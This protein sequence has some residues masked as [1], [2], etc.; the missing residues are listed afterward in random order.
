MLLNGDISDSMEDFSF[1]LPVSASFVVATFYVDCVVTV[2]LVLAAASDD[3][4]ERRNLMMQ[5]DFDGNVFENMMGC[6]VYHNENN[7]STNGKKYFQMNFGFYF[8][9]FFVQQ[10]DMSE[11]PKIC[12]IACLFTCEN[13]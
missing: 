12:S 1:T 10:Y 9:F 2:Q 8:F 4:Q 11:R 6:G 7:V 5:N 13:T 3:Q